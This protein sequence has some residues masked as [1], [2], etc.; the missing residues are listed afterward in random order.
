MDQLLPNS[1][2]AAGPK[3]AATAAYAASL[4][5]T[6][7][8]GILYGLTVYNSKASAQFIQLHD[9]AA[10][11]A[12]AAV[13]ALVL[14][15]PATSHLVIDLGAHGKPFNTGI[16]ACNSSTGPT[17]TIGLADCFIEARFKT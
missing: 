8:R 1:S 6:A 9:A 13:P 2:V 15:I 3:S 4:V 7:Q 17:K 14:T 10:L 11:P 5:V 12:D 16:V